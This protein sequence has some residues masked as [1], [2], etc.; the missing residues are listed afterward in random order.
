MQQKDLAYAYLES[1]VL[2]E[3]SCTIV[4]LGLVTAAS[5]DPD[6]NGSSLAVASLY[7]KNG[8]RTSKYN[9]LQMH[10]HRTS[11]ATRKPFASSLTSVAGAL[12]TYGGNSAAAAPKA[13]T[14]VLPTRLHQQRESRETVSR[15]SS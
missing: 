9:D 14:P 7:C 8:S 1:H 2:E 12:R 3:V 11:E 5:I 10:D 4:L 13:R 6:T 15:F